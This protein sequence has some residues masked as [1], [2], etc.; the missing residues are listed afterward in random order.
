LAEPFPTDRDRAPGSDH[1][2][3]ICI[4][5][6]RRQRERLFAFK[7]GVSFSIPESSKPG[8]YKRV[9]EIVAAK[10]LTTALVGVVVLAVVV[11]M[12]EL[13]CTAG[14]PA[15][16]TQ[17]LTMHERPAWKNYGYLGLY[18]LAY[19]LDDTI[20]LTIVVVTLSHRKLQERE[21]RWLKHIHSR[22]DFAFFHSSPQGMGDD[23]SQPGL[24][25]RASFHGIFLRL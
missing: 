25:N 15:L 22:I 12:V 9:R 17:V 5:D 11:N 20:L 21:G 19:M 24:Q 14:L 3:T 13:L 10:Y 8:I 18:I 4:S 6:R 1:P 2:W 16:Y 7:K 23:E